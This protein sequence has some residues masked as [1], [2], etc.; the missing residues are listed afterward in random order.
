MVVCGFR[1]EFV[2]VGIALAQDGI[3]SAFLIASLPP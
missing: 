2:V 3:D 1:P